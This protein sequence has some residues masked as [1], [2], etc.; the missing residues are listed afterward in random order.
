MEVA[1]AVPSEVVGLVDTLFPTMPESQT[2]K[3]DPQ[4]TARIS[5]QSSDSPNGYHL[6]LLPSRDMIWLHIFAVSKCSALT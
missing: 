5:R 2:I 1:A 6:V 3:L 4:K